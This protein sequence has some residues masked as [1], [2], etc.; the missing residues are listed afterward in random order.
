[1]NLLIMFHEIHRLKREGFSNAWISRHLVLNRRTVTKYLHMSEENYLSFKDTGRPRNKLLTRYEDFVRMRLEECPDASAAQV[2]DWLKEHFEDFIEVNEKTVF[3][4][5]LA[6]RNKYDIPKLFHY[7]DF[8]KVEEL[9]FGKQAQADFG[10]YNM[11]TEEG[12]RKKVYFFVMVLSASRQKYVVYRD[13]PFTTWAM[14]DAHEQCFVFLMGVT[15]HVVY[16]QDKL[17]LVSENHGDLLLTQEFKSYVN[18]RGIS[19]HFCRKADPQSKGKIEN[20]IKY[21]KYNFL[22]GRKYSN[23]SLLNQQSAQWLS[24]TA[25]AKTHAAT[26]KIPQQEWEREKSFLKPLEG[27]YR[28]EQGNQWYNVRK[29]NTIAYKGN[30]YCLPKGTYTGPQTRVIVMLM[31]ESLVLSDANQNEIARHTL[32]CGKGKLIGNNNYNRDYSLKIDLLIDHIAANY[33]DPVSAREYLNQIRKDNPRYIRDQ[34]TLIK[35]QTQT[36]GMK[37]MEQALSFCIQNKIFKATDME[38][39][40]KKILAETN[41][42]TP[43]PPAT[44]RVK[45]LNKSTFKITPEKSS[46]ADYKNLMN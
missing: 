22:R 21:I 23:I 35:K 29:D 30:F 28:S 42:P 8:G 11:T 6:V 15:Q 39:V 36:Y 20:V 37:V 10:E 27:I 3:N 2:H 31:D 46:I 43:E 32:A 16:D 18:Y 38:S 41:N 44:I 12:M 33:N 5:V 25:N 19:L 7:R 4:F 17:A 14:I 24:R 26:R 13:S 45:S 1:M 9:P 40:A 34:L